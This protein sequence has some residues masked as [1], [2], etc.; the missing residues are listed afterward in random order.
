MLLSIEDGIDALTEALCE[1]H[2][3]LPHGYGRKDGLDAKSF[4]ADQA[5]WI[6]ADSVLP[7]HYTF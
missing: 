6:G 3:Q 5:A 1:L 4:K 7:H 2:F